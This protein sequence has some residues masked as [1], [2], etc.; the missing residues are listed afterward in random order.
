[1]INKGKVTT[2][3]VPDTKAKTLKPIIEAMVKN[4][5]IVVTD[6]W[7]GYVGLSNNYQHEVVNHNINEFVKN[8]YHTNAIEGYWSLLKRGIYG[9]YHFASPKHL[10]KYCDEFSYRYNTRKITDSDRFMMSL[11]NTEGRLTYK[12]LIQK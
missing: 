1:M 10:G 2:N 8:G 3:V 11:I 12:Q 9:I 7:N 4:G 6:E 5:S